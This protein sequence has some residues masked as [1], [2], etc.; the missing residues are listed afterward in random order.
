MAYYWVHFTGNGAASLLADCRIGP[1]LH[2]AGASPSVTGL[3]HQLFEA[4]IYR[5]D[6]LEPAAAGLLTSLLVALS[7]S[8]NKWRTE[9][10]PPAPE[11]LSRSI[12]Y[13]H[14]HSSRPVTLSCLA[15]LEHLSVSRY[16]A[17]FRRCMG[18]SPQSFLIDLRLRS[19]VALLHKTDL[20]IK[21]IASMVGYEDPLYFSRLFR[22]RLG[23]SPR[24]Y[25]QRNRP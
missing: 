4:F 5:D 16:S 17:L 6:C 9:P 13:L 18:Q 3:F 21:Q 10:R 14:Q 15:A 22:S 23:I 19:A 25:Q 7:R 11:R 2:L 8:R 24:L 12:D 1:G 20:S